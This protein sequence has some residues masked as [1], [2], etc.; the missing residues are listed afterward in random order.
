M[1]T[2]KNKFFLFF[3]LAL[4]LII[5][6]TIVNAED[7]TNFTAAQ[8]KYQE[9][10]TKIQELQRQGYPTLPLIEMLDLARQSFN[11]L[12][13]NASYHTS[14]QIISQSETIVQLK[15]ELDELTKGIS[16][17][18]L[19]GEDTTE[20]ELQLL[21]A[22]SD[23]ESANIDLS[24]SEAETLKTKTS[25]IYQ[26]ISSGKF[27]ELKDYSETLK[28]DNKNITFFNEY[29][30]KQRIL[31]EQRRYIDFLEGDSNLETIK[32]IISTQEELEKNLE[33]ITSEEISLR[34]K[35]DSLSLYETFL[36]T[37]DYKNAEKTLAE[38]NML[39]KTAIALKEEMESLA[40]EYEQIRE[41]GILDNKTQ[42]KYSLA[43]KEYS[44]ENYI[45]SK[46]LFDETRTALSE[47]ER[48]N[49]IFGGIARAQL[50]RGLKDFLIQNWATLIILTILITITFKPAKTYSMMKYSKK[51]MEKL[52]SEKEII[53]EL[54]KELQKQYYIE[55]FIDKKT[56]HEDFN[57]YE[58]RKVEIT[59]KLAMLEENH[60]EYSDYMEKL[61][62]YARILNKKIKDAV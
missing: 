40:I 58:E 29:Y 20:L 32:K 31:Y 18:I 55:H 5:L 50:K 37:T 12:D 39:A 33:T 34:R 26:N 14:Q 38:L 56:Y 15:T 10:D 3:I 6:L 61:R 9:A 27:L 19:Y 57:R 62:K 1:E 53:I 54:Q 28:Q 11:N 52:T 59:N 21:Y 49:I 22:K 36:N 30:N 17:L 43:M 48:Q 24:K 45:E 16:L 46:K 41:L 51:Q 60:K 23:F 2:K 7:I 44:L 4:I 47:L 25:G 13:Y 8:A 35:D 42:E